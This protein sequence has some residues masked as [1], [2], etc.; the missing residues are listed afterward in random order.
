MLF[1]VALVYIYTRMYWLR[2]LH[3][4]QLK[5]N[6]VLLAKALT[7]ARLRFNCLHAL[8]ASHLDMNAR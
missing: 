2:T 5:G 6:A 7:L 1:T 3:G 8:I 4:I